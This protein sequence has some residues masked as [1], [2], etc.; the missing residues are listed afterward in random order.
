MYPI[1]KL[2]TH[3]RGPQRIHIRNLKQTSA[4]V[5][6]VLPLGCFTIYYYHHYCWE[7]RH[8]YAGCITVAL[9]SA[10]AYLAPVLIEFFAF[11]REILDQNAL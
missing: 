10:M 7:T 8:G 6:D 1:A 9:T 4:D 11:R 3:S 5:V 2:Y